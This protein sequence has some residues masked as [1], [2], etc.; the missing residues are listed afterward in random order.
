MP[1]FLVGSGAIILVEIMGGG[2][3]VEGRGRFLRLWCEATVE[4]QTEDLSGIISLRL[5]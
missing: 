5:L 1:L 2:G 3:P 4:I